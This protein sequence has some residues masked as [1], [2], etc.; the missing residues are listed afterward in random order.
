MGGVGEKTVAYSL[1]CKC[2][3]NATVSRDERSPVG[4]PSNN[5]QEWVRLRGLID[6]GFSGL[7]FTRITVKM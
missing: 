1:A 4:R 2:D 7:R 5:F 3:F 6:V